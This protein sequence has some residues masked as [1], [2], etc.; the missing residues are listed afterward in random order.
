M[1]FV[2]ERGSNALIELYISYLVT[3]FYFGQHPFFSAIFFW[4]P[5]EKNLTKI[6]GTNPPLRPSV[7][8][9]RTSEISTCT[10]VISS[11]ILHAECDFPTR[12]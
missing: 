8:S 10:R 3:L 4:G 11:V 9:K 2:P 1:R 12:V 7:I 5:L 6:W